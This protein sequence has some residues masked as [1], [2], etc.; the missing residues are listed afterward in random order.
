MANTL[1]D[2]GREAFLLGDIDWVADTI[3]VVLV[4]SDYVFSVS[5]QYL[6]SID[7]ADRIATATLASKSATNGIADAADIT[8]TAVAAGS[9]CPA[10]VIYKDTG[11]AATSPLIA[12]IDTATGLPITTTGGDIAVVW[13]GGVNKIFKL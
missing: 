6:S 10:L 8:Y 13:D 9:T 7:A 12:Y 4:E 11:V 2:K 1:Y 3:K 5:H